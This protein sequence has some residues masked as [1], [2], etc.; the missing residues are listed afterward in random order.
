MR[1]CVGKLTFSVR[2]DAGNRLIRGTEYLLDNIVLM[3]RQLFRNMA[4]F[5]YYEEGQ[6]DHDVVRS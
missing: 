6:N 5:F 2:L 4:P 3:Y 1:L